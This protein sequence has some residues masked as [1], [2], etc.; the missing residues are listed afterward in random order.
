MNAINANS[1]H[2]DLALKYQELVNTNQEYR[3]ILRYGIE[4]V[5]FN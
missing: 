3:D 4:G 2:I 1:E 5:H